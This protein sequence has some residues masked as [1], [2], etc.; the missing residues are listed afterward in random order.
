MSTIEK[1]ELSRNRKYTVGD[2]GGKRE[3]A[4]QAIAVEVWR[5]M[6]EFS[7]DSFQRS[8]H[9]AILKELGLTPGHM[10]VL[11]VLEPDDARPMGV[12]AEACHCDPSMATWLVDRLEERGLVR[13]GSLTTDR[14]VKT[15]TLTPDGVETKARLLAQLYEPPAELV[16]LDRATLETLRGA[17]E[18]LPPTATAGLWGGRSK[19]ER[20]TTG[21]G[22][23]QP[24]TT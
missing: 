14:R 13:R 7:M 24:V 10:K 19:A 11:S 5:M 15:V 8:L 21:V 18:K 6:A 17:L 4:K 23:R 3:G 9:V 1:L 12:I 20:H 22:A 2:M 16:A